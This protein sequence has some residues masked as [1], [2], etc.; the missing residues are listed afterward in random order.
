MI[1]LHQQLRNETAQLTV[2][3][4]ELKATE[5][6]R[7]DKRLDEER[8][9]KLE[10]ITEAVIEVQERE[11]TYL[12]AELHDNI[13]Q[14]LAT[15][16]LYIDTAIQNESVRLNL[17][18]ESKEFIRNAMEE[19]RALCKSL[20]PPALSHTSLID[21]LDDFIQNIKQVDQVQIITEWENIDESQMCDKMK[22][23]IFRIVQEQFN[24]IFKHAR[25][26]T[27]IVRLVQQNDGLQLNIKDDGIG[28][29]TSQKRNGVGLQNIISRASLLKGEV[30]VNSRIGAGCELSVAFQMRVAN[31]QQRLAS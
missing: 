4:E 5:K 26:K 11:R 10:E 24:N 1:E 27:I 9:K 30:M 23:T 22:L 6:I 2:A 21:A 15:S 29:N 3:H 28:F 17:I 14:I 19:I 8:I 16:R 20:L 18:T 13:N 7:I 25:A 31:M 12:A